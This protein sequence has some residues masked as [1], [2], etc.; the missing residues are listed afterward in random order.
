MRGWRR[1]GMP[2]KRD[3]KRRSSQAQ[4]RAVLK[5]DLQLLRQPSETFCAAGKAPARRGNYPA[6]ARKH[7]GLKFRIEPCREVV[8]PA[9]REG[10]I[11][12]S[13]ATRLGGAHVQGIS[14]DIGVGGIQSQLG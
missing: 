2:A 14:N 11:S 1:R 5:Q 8:S 12:R 7:L 10:C 6:Y 4:C 3:R 9:D 13:G